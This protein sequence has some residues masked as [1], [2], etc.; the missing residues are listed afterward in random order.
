MNS[1]R[2]G[3]KTMLKNCKNAKRDDEVPLIHNK[4][5]FPNL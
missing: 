2:L 1:N 3:G 4:E 5:G